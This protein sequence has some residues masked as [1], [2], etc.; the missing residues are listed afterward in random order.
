MELFELIH[1]VALDF[2]E[3]KIAKN[4]GV[5]TCMK[6]SQFIMSDSWQ[7]HVGFMP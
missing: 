2:F 4:Q 5:E 1:I 3:G 6:V 7:I